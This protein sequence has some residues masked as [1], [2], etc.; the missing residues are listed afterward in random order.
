MQKV[1]STGL[2]LALLGILGLGIAACDDSAPGSG[3]GD[4]GPGGEGGGGD[5]GDG[6]P[7]GMGGEGGAANTPCIEDSECAASQY[8]DRAPG[9]F[10]G[11]C[12]AGCRA[13]SCS[14]G[15]ICNADHICVMPGCDGDDNFCSAGQYCDAET[16]ACTDGCRD[17]VACP[18]VDG[19]NAVCNDAH[20]CE[21]LFPCCD[22]SD[23]CTEQTEAACGEGRLLRNVLTCENNPC[24]DPTCAGDA[25]CGETQFCNTESSLCED[26]CRAG[27]RCPDANLTCDPVTHECIQVACEGGDSSACADW[28]FCDPA[29]NLCREGECR[30][31]AD[32]EEGFTCLVGTCQMICDPNGPN[33]CGDSGICRPDTMLCDEICTVETDNC[34]LNEG[35]NFETGLCE[36]GRCRDDL[37]EPNNDVTA[38]TPI[39][40][41]AAGAGIRMGHIDGL[42]LCQDNIADG[43]SEPEDY[44]A[45]TL[46]QGE[47]LQVTLNN[48]GV[49]DV[50]IDIELLGDEVDGQVV[51]ATLNDFERIEYPPAN[52]PIR[53]AT[54]YYVRVHGDIDAFTV[55]SLNV[56]VVASENPCFPDP[57]EPG[58]NNRAG[59]TRLFAANNPNQARFLGSICVGDEDWFQTTFDINDGFTAELSTPANSAPLRLEAYSA[60]TVNGPGG[61]A[62]AEFRV[63]AGMQVGGRT[64]Y[65]ITAAENTNALATD[66]WYFRIRSTE[67][68]GF[69]DYEF[70][71]NA[72]RVNNPCLPDALEPN[73]TFGTSLQ[74]D[75][76]A[77]ISQGGQVIAGVE[78]TVAADLTICPGDADWFCLTA[79]EGNVLEA[80]VVGES[81]LGNIN[82]RW[83]NAVGGNVGSGGMGTAPGDP[84]LPARVP[85][86]AA[87]RYCAVVTGEARSEGIYTLSIRRNAVAVNDQCL[88][89]VAE[90]APGTG[91]RNDNPA[92][93]AALTDVGAVMGQR[94]VYEEGLL[95]NLNGNADVDWYTFPVAEAE[96]RV[97]VTIDGFA[98]DRADVDLQIF[99][100]AAADPGVACANDAVCGMGAACIQGR[101]RPFVSQSLSSYDVEMVALTRGVTGQF[102]GPHYVKVYRGEDGATEPYRVQATVTPPNPRASCTEDWQELGSPNNLSGAATFLGGGDIAICDAW[103]CAGEAN[104]GDWYELNIPR[105]QDRTV[106]VQN[107]RVTD[108]SL[109]MTLFSDLLNDGTDLDTY[110]DV[111]SAT[112]FQCLNIEGS[113]VED[114]TVYI[115]L[116]GTVRNDVPRNDY[117]LRVVPTDVSANP[118]GACV[119]LG[120]IGLDPCDPDQLMSDQYHANGC[121]P[122]FSIE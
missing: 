110:A 52:D 4:S 111:T 34:E 89:D 38:A 27:A 6:G 78:H 67:A 82:V 13:T 32:C 80:W 119:T 21:A 16:N 42:I 46:A 62:N 88:Q 20:V 71:V 76:R 84:R 36:T 19:H 14:P 25:D 24:D 29:T 26:G 33:T 35:C 18:L 101:C 17:G 56:V 103:L 11:L 94:F 15:Q 117:S 65:R 55:Y 73:D 7:G 54:T 92:S 114:R 72:V 43:Q 22:G 28:Q 30:E 23:A 112:D 93:A 87:G 104:Q 100:A 66:T 109:T 9:A 107:L 68:Q 3:G 98:N 37:F 41:V 97:C 44:Y 53:N 5:G 58:D 108:G 90:N 61:L 48:P 50:D 122:T 96:S 115:N 47:R 77:G 106:F 31:N 40:L 12:V 105:G 113:D 2:K 79:E 75:A 116:R 86:V 99:R 8:C 10:D 64:V 51:S 69:A 60:A 39:E 70:N 102:T 121:Y 63:D 91:R 45:I 1:N 59:A 83:V 74:L 85:G 49:G 120:G 81:L 57:R 118:L 95:C